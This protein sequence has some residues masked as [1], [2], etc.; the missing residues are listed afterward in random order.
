MTKPITLILFAA[1]VAAQL[2]VPAFMIVQR[3]GTLQQGVAYKFRCAPVDPYDAFRGKYVALSLQTG[4]DLSWSGDP[5]RENQPIYVSLSVDTEGFAQVDSLSLTRPDFGD[6]VQAK[7]QWNTAGQTD[8]SLAFPF[9]RYYLEESKAPEAERVY[10]ES[11]R[12]AER[13]TY[14]TVRI[15]SGFGVLEELYINDTP[16]HEFLQRELQ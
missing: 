14:I 7:V 1:M 2:G 4:G 6:Y 11:L 12:E 9:D 8:V 5:L 13:S 16:V 10:R 15:K 3:E